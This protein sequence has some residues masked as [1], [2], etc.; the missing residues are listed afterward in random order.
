MTAMLDMVEAWILD[1][2]ASLWIY[3]A[4]FASAFIDG[5]FPPIPSESVLVTLV[6]SAQA[7]GVPWIWLIAPIA[8]I[9]AWLGDQVAYVL[10]R[11]L[12]TERIGMLRSR[13]GRKAVSWARR[14]LSRRGA[15][16]IIAARYIP[17]GRVAVN[18]TAGAVGYPQRRF[19]TFSGIAAV[20]WVAYST[21]IGLVAAEVLGHNTLLAM[22]VGVIG[23]GLLGLV[24]DRVVQ[25]FTPREEVLDEMREHAPLPTE[26]SPPEPAVEDAVG[27][28]R[29]DTT[30]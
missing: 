2:A 30:R 24:V 3:P 16:F 10:G 15:V 8:G 18:M 7:T 19:M 28:A 6:I 21:A 25:I 26:K 17:V 13:R 11:K 4:M 9:G 1:V 23:G 22:V 29:Q 20:L 12:G 27:A 5:F 14:A